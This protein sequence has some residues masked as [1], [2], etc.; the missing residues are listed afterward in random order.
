V[1]RYCRGVARGSSDHAGQQSC[2]GEGFGGFHPP[3]RFPEIARY[4]AARIC[5]SSCFNAGGSNN[6]R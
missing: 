4:L 2:D 5:D 6:S 1:F 3:G